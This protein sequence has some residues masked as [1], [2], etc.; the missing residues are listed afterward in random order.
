VTSIHRVPRFAVSAIL[1]AALG[2]VAERADCQTTMSPAASGS[3]TTPTE[4]QGGLDAFVD[5]FEAYDDNVLAHGA[6]ATA[7]RPESF[8]SVGGLYSGLEHTVQYA[9]VGDPDGARFRSWTTG[10]VRYYPDL[11][12]FTVAH[13]EVGA[14][15]QVVLGRRLRLYGS[16]FGAYSP[17]YSMR[18]FS[19]PGD[20]NDDDLEGRL[21]SRIVAPGLDADYSVI[22]R[23]NYRYGGSSG[24]QLRLSTA[25]TLS[26]TYGYS[27]SEFQGQRVDLEVQRSGATFVHRLTR[28]ASLRLGYSRQEGHYI[29][30]ERQLIEQID[31]GVDYSRPL[32]RTRRTVLRFTSGSAVAE[33]GNRRRMQ[34]LGTASV[35][36]QIGRTWVAR[37]GYRRSL[38]HLEGFDRQVLSDE[39][40]TTLGGF[41]TRRLEFSTTAS[42]FRGTVGI[43]ARSPKFDSYSSVGRLRAAVS[44][45]LAAYV[46]YFF[47]QYRFAD[48]GIRPIGLPQSFD[49]RGA[50]VGV[51]LYVP[52]ID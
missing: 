2:V 42:F 31:L 30:R 9:G 12:Q 24:I 7:G 48:G 23:E 34:M 37:A 47:Y 18:L 38:R 25:S 15:F 10:A 19:Q 28:N 51:S 36:R 20:E 29:T 6:G 17:R 16:P 33:E 41:W 11:K 21:T 14:A 22:E 45:T 1:I 52:L 43:S 44:R 40:S 39:A 26:L 8:M 46:E 32:S 35:V 49:R 13:Q 27:N 50:R 5:L 3:G 4:E